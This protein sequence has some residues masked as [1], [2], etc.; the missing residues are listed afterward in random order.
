MPWDF[1]Y[2]SSYVLAFSG[3]SKS[4]KV[5][6]CCLC[7]RGVVLDGK[8]KEILSLRYVIMSRPHLMNPSVIQHKELNLIRISDVQY[9]TTHSGEIAGGSR[10]IDILSN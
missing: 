9:K 8:L 2:V 6:L 3:Y 10:P 1:V 7:F 5:K 4:H